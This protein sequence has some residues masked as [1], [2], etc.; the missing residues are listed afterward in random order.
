MI[1]PKEMTM[2][3]IESEID[4]LQARRR[5]LVRQIWNIDSDLISLKVEKEK[6][7]PKGYDEK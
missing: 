3:E 2:N 6:R 4:A 5:E 7:K 1:E